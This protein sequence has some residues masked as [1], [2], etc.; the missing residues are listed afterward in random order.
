MQSYKNIQYKQISLTNKFKNQIRKIEKRD[1]DINLSAVCYGCTWSD[2]FSLKNLK[3][4]SKSTSMSKIS[5][6]YSFIKDLVGLANINNHK[7]KSLI[8]NGK[9]SEITMTWGNQDDFDKFGN[10]KDRYFNKKNNILKKKLKF[11]FITGKFNK[12]KL[13]SGNILFLNDNK[14]IKIWSL[15]KI[16]Y[17]IFLKYNCSIYKFYNYANFYS[18]FAILVFKNIKKIIIKYKIKV[19]HIPYEGQPFQKY[20]IQGLKITYPKIKI[21][22]YAHASQ[23]LPLHML[24]K[25]NKMDNLIVSSHD[26]YH[27]MK[28][29]LG[30]PK[31]KLILRKNQKID[32][33]DKKKFLNKIF[34]PYGVVD[35]QLIARKFK[36][37]VSRGIVNAQQ[38][39]VKNHPLMSE[40]KNHLILIKKLKE[41][42]SQS[43]MTNNHQ[44][45]KYCILLGATSSVPEALQSIDYVYHI[46]QDSVIEVYTKY[47][48]PN[49]KGSVIED[50][51][52]KYNAIDR[53]K[54]F[55][56]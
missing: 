27:Q 48:W 23:P 39:T 16:L 15:L 50:N 36:K 31:K 19:L 6:F 37:L 47:F 42:I 56:I 20:L 45:K 28:N 30:W 17:E 4:L 34:L 38:L 22:G 9:Y 29:R 10:F 12:I 54:L 53:K 41:I 2:N 1:L 51:I 5:L 13:L 14:K 49:I 35:P 46:Y 40:S 7:V 24:N 11:I 33:I 3:N 43:K 18:L 26:H 32:K 8:D 52:I 55:F 44:N 25:N 21:F